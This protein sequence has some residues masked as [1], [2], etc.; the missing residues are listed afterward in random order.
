MDL[1]EEIAVIAKNVSRF[2]ARNNLKW[3]RP[4][5][6]S[7]HRTADNT[8][9]LSVSGQDIN[10]K[11]DACQKRNEK[12]FSQHVDKSAKMLMIDIQAE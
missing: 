11:Q 12:S 5:A 2:F 10:Q 6:R 9:I 3:R 8:W 4:K 7:L 1:N